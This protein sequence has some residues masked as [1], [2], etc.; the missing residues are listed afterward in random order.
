[1]LNHFGLEAVEGGYCGWHTILEG[2][3]QAGSYKCN[4]YAFING[5]V[6]GEA[7]PK[8][9]KPKNQLKPTFLLLG[10]TFSM[11]STAL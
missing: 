11:L 7:K 9:K 3:A 10:K 4:Y 6:G 8:K 5:G 1:M 2:R